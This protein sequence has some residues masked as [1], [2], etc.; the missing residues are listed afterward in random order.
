MSHGEHWEHASLAAAYTSPARS[1]TKRAAEAAAPG[2]WGESGSSLAG[3]AA[4]AGVPELEADSP[5]EGWELEL[6]ERRGFRQLDT[7]VRQSG[8]LLKAYGE[9]PQRVW[10]SRFLYLTADRLCYTADPTA[11]SVRYLPLDRIPVRALPRGYGPKLGVSL[12]EDRQVRAWDGEGRAG[13][14]TCACCIQ[15]S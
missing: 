7:A 8:W 15:G 5:L 2:V 13:A 6:V 14:T 11:D 4:A 3:T 12:V 1:P 10:R 9:G